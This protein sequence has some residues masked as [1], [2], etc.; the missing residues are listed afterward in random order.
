M[1]PSRRSERAAARARPGGEPHPV[2]RS[3]AEDGRAPPAEVRER[4]LADLSRRHRPAALR[5]QHLGDELEL[6]HVE[7]RLC[8]ALERRRRPPRSCPRDRTRGRPRAISRR[9]RT[10]G[11]PAPG[12]PAWTVVRTPSAAG[13][14]ALGARD[15]GEVEPV[16]RRADE[17]G[18]A[19]IP[20]RVEPRRRVLAAARDGQR[21]EDPRALEPGPEADEEAEREREE[22]RGRSAP[23]PRPGTRR[24][25]SAPTT[26][27]T[28]R[29]RASGSAGP[30][31]P[32]S[33][34]R[35]RSARAGACGS[36]RTA[37]APPGRRPAR[38]FVRRGSLAKS[39]QEPTSRGSRTPA[40]WRRPRQKAFEPQISP[41]PAAS[42][43]HCHRRR[44]SGGAVS[45][46]RSRNGTS[47]PTS[48]P[49]TT[50]HFPARRASRQARAGPSSR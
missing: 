3:V 14:S 10:A 24:P 18:G 17:R 49:L 43:S 38:A 22:E 29:S 20:D 23:A 28:P 37:G 11:M 25:S 27:T 50:R 42:R 13:S 41:S 6:V 15:L 32:T 8:D 5:V 26:P 2:A 48:R 4:Q 16:G 21:A 40:A 46:A 1:P 47:A 30:W 35:A 9:A 19:E 33:G 36:C 39:A 34:T 45:R 7:A 31:C 12:S 44:R